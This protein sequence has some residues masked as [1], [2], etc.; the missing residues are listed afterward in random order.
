MRVVIVHYHARPGGVSSVM[1]RHAR[2]LLSMGTSVTILTGEPVPEG[3]EWAGLDCQVLPELGYSTQRMSPNSLVAL[4]AKLHKRAAG[5]VLHVHNPFLGKNVSWPDLWTCLVAAGQPM[6]FHQHDFVEDNRQSLLEQF[7]DRSLWYPI[8]ENACWVVLNRRDAAALAAAGVA[9]RQ[10]RVLPNPVLPSRLGRRPISHPGATEDT[11]PQSCIWY[12]TRALERKNLGEL[13]LWACLAPKGVTFLASV[14]AHGP[15]QLARLSRW[16]D[17]SAEL[18]LPIT[19]A[20]ITACQ[21]PVHCVLSTSIQEGFGYTFA[22]PWLDDVPVCGRFLPDAMD[23]LLQAGLT[24]PNAY[25]AIQVQADSEDFG[26]LPEENQKAILRQLVLPQN[27]AQ[28]RI[29]LADGHWITAAQWFERVLADAP[30]LVRDNRACLEKQ[31]SPQRIANRLLGIYENIF[32]AAPGLIGHAD[33][34][35][36]AQTYSVCSAKQNRLDKT[37]C[38]PI[39]HANQD[40]LNLVK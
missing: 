26:A 18:H 31:F 17:L 14:Q 10:L 30:Q 16:Q 33:A 15:E 27:R 4:A 36:V 11:V 28:V 22:E 39:C 21:H 6:V 19:W 9:Q 1:Q 7:P 2:A 34:A 20:D 12:P 5:A 3:D 35:M 38:A 13:L 29:Q 25:V 8:A 37:C 32:H 40:A 23:C 24:Y